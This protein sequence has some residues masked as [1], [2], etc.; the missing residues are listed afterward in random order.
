MQL[1]STQCLTQPYVALKFNHSPE[2]KNFKASA[3][4]SVCIFNHDSSRKMRGQT[5]HEGKPAGEG[6]EG[7]FETSCFDGLGEGGV[8][9]PLKVLGGKP[10]RCCLEKEGRGTTSP[11]A[12]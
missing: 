4:C 12:A 1:G 6:G 5:S 10:P 2:I 7:C 3:S 9:L 11:P 8:P